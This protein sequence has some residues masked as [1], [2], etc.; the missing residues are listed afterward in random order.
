MKFGKINLFYFI[1]ANWKAGINGEHS[2]WRSLFWFEGVPVDTLTLFFPS[3]NKFL[4]K[5]TS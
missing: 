2:G 4:P 5:T 1:Q 3:M